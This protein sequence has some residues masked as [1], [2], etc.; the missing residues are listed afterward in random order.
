MNPVLTSFSQSAVRR[1]NV[2]DEADVVFV[3]KPGETFSG[4]VERIVAASGQSQMSASGQLTSFT[5]MTVTDRWA[6]II[7]L[8]DQAVARSLPQGTAGTV[9][10]YTNAGKPLHVISKVAMRMSAWLSYLTS[11]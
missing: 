2:G 10:V 8:D 6:V 11:P 4:K 9:A 3:G 5:G 1:I 7:E